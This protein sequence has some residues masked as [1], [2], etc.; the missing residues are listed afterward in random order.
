MVRALEHLRLRG[1]CLSVKGSRNKCFFLGV[2][3]LAIYHRTYPQC[4]WTKETQFVTLGRGLRF[5]GRILHVLGAPSGSRDYH[6]CILSHRIESY[7]MY[8]ALPFPSQ[9]HPA[10]TIPMQMGS[11]A[12]LSLKT[13]I[14]WR[15]TELLGRS[16][17]TRFLRSSLGLFGTCYL[18]LHRFRPRWSLTCTIF[19]IFHMMLVLGVL[20]QRRHQLGGV[21]ACFS[22]VL[23]AYVLLEADSRC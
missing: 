16:Y 18:I 1:L 2:A 6:D 10:L 23:G 13:D 15:D 11:S 19:T 4:A 17:A 8:A 20:C 5:R 3:I 7:Q 14:M 12:K 22:L 21:V 9:E